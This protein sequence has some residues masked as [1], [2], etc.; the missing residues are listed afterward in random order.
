[1]YAS[2]GGGGGGGRNQSCQ[3]GKSETTQIRTA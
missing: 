1:M 2:G 3:K